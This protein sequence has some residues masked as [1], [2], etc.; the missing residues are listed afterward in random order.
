MNDNLRVWETSLYDDNFTMGGKLNVIY[1]KKQ[2]KKPPRLE[3][4]GKL[5]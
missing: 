3:V 4:R 5:N 1:R 2:N